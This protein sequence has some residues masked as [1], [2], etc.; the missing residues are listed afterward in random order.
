M[1]ERIAR[2]GETVE[3]MLR[4]A[5]VVGLSCDFE[6][7]WQAAG[8]QEAQ[9]MDALEAALHAKLLE[10]DEQGYRFR[11][12]LFRE[13]I[14]GGLSR[15]RRK[16]MHGA[17]ADAIAEGVRRPSAQG[18]HAVR[19]HHL[20]AAGRSAEAL[21]HLL[22]A[23][24]AA[25]DRSGL[26]EALGFF[27][28]ALTMMEALG[29]RPA[30]ERFMVHRRIGAIQLALSDSAE[31]LAHLDSALRTTGADD[32]WEPTNRERVNVLCLAADAHMNLEQLDD[33]DRLLQQA[34]ELAE[35]GSLELPELLCNVAHLRWNQ[36]RARDAYAIAQ[37]AVSEAERTLDRDALA[38]GYEMLALAC[39]SLGEWHE[40]MGFVEKRKEIAGH[41][42]EVAGTF[43]AHL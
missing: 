22:R 18:A 19:A 41:T 23:G 32:G 1:H 21:P 35:S 6:W 3:L 31:A 5:S 12:A 33:A 43:D 27:E 26:Q 13:A 14:Y 29:N 16:S 42:V 38:K 15:Q 37:R 24:R 25:M 7:V 39:H 28:S 20:R 10:E 11:H 2:L 40:G 36:G 9:A 34:M 8:L 30:S 4:F 17:I